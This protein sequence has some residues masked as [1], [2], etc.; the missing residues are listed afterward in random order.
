M[1]KWRWAAFLAWSFLIAT[2]PARGS[3]ILSTGPASISTGGPSEGGPA[4]AAC[5]ESPGPLGQCCDSAAGCC[6]EEAP[7]PGQATAGAPQTSGQKPKTAASGSDPVSVVNGR[8]TLVRTDLVVPG[9][10][11]IE[12][13]RRYDSQSTY[14]SPLGYGWSF[15]FDLKLSEYKDG[16]VVVRNGCGYRHRFELQGG[17]YVSEVGRKETLTSNGNG[18]YLLEYPRGEEAFFN[19][20]GNLEELRD[21]NGNKLFFEYSPGRVDLQGT[22]PYAVDPTTPMLVAQVYQLTRVYE[23]LADST[24]TGREVTFAYDGNGRLDRATTGSAAGGNLREVH[25]DHDADGNLIDVRLPVQNMVEEIVE[26]YGYDP[27]R[28]PG[29]PHN[30]TSIQLGQGETTWY[31]RYDAQDRVTEQTRGDCGASCD[32]ELTFDYSTPL[33]TVVTRTIKDPSGTTVNTAIETFEYNTQNFLVKRIDALGNEFDY[34]RDGN[35]FLDR[36]EVRHNHPTGGL[37]LQKTVEYTYDLA[38]NLTKKEVTLDPRNGVT[39]TITEEWQ[40]EP[41]SDWVSAYEVSSSIPASPVFRTEY[42]FYGTGSGITNIREIKRLKDDGINFETTLLTYDGNGQLETITPPAVTP[43]D[44]L[45]IVRRYASIP[46]TSVGLLEEIELEVSGAPDPH[47]KRTFTYDPRGFLDSVTD[48]RSHTTHYVWDDL[49]RLTEVRNDLAESTFF[50][51]RGPSPTDPFSAAPPGRFLSEVEIGTTV[52]DGEGQVR[53][54]RYDA[55]GR[56]DR[57]ERKDDSDTW[58]TFVTYFYDSD[59]N[60]VQSKDAVDRDVLFEYDLLDRLTQVTDEAPTPNVTQF[61]YD[62]VGN[63]T[64]ILD[65]KLRQTLF[66]YDDLDRLTEVEQVAETLT[67]AFTYDA[68][69]NVTNVTDAKGQETDYAY[70]TRSRLTSVTQEL[71]QD[72]LYAYDDRGRLEKTTNARDQVLDY[73]YFPWGGLDKV[74]HRASAGAAVDRTVSYTYDDVGNLLTTSDSQLDPDPGTPGVQPLYTFTYDALDRVDLV[75]AHYLPG[76]DRTLDSDYDRFANRD[77]LVFTDGVDVLTHTWHFNDLDRLEWADLASPTRIDFGYYA[78][79]ELHTITRQATAPTT[80]PLSTYSYWPHGPVQQILVTG[81]PGELLK[82]DYTVDPTLNVDDVTETRDGTTSGVFDYGYDGIDRLTGADYPNAFGLPADESFIYDPAGNRDDA[83]SQGTFTYDANNR[84]QTSAGFSWTFDADGNVL[85]RTETA[86][87]TE[88]RFTFDKTNRLEAWEKGPVGSPTDTASY[89][90]DPF[91]RRVQKTVN[92]VTTWF[93]WDGDA[94]AAEFDGSGLRARRYTYA[95]GFAPIEVADPA[96]GGGEDVYDVHTD[97][98]DTPRM[99]TDAGQAV[100]WRQSHEAYGT[101]VL[102]PG[103]SVTDFQVR[104]PGQ[105]LDEETGFHY[106]FF[107][108]HDPSVGRYISADPIGQRADVNTFSYARNDPM[109][110]V[111]PDGRDPLFDGSGAHIAQTVVDAMN[112]HGDAQAASDKADDLEK[113]GRFGPTV[114]RPGLEPRSKSD[115]RHCLASC[116]ITK[117]Q[118]AANA[119]AF[120]DARE[121]IL[122]KGINS[123]DNAID[124]RANAKGREFGESCDDCHKKCLDWATAGG[125]GVLPVSGPFNGH[126]E[127]PVGLGR[128]SVQSGSQ[129]ASSAKSPSSSSSRSP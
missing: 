58:S 104:F 108:Y 24:V 119:K 49:G 71:G 124:Q 46:A 54:M 11:P 96:A 120:G 14:D 53:R 79:D 126:I 84:I 82:L 100:V 52:A 60:R 39:E 35:G 113:S 47:L 123:V 20:Q 94:L 22:S 83:S 111:D 67:T 15:A 2:V 48:A 1:D 42:T 78:N 115:Y 25:Y 16:S 34:I 74:E 64:E 128:G 51:Y 18:T 5:D 121:I 114:L 80:G 68:A 118:G 72:V 57:V 38:W 85:T 127:I 105:Y 9:V 30:L 70:D 40:Y 66:R 102:D 10:Y 75:T 33:T 19:V 125:G 92:G 65:A 17:Q 101:A 91:G 86:T 88:E 98:L 99:L 87:S 73:T 89:L 4:N 37:G 76:G 59:D 32:R 117:S 129:R 21:R 45:K 97:H 23:E 43:A 61:A 56:L 62:A 103:N 7:A 109:A 50:R 81:T 27:T 13:T 106:N 63:R 95:G 90:Y 44:G 93:L 28:S 69:G 8:H 36:V 112:A 122:G 41:G 3:D 31:M 110:F 12:L 6:E 107:R 26:T 29:Q 55:S 77:G 116:L